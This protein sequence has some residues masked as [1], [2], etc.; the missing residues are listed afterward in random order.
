MM[1]LAETHWSGVVEMKDCLAQAELENAFEN[2]CRELIDL[3]FSD[4]SA[5]GGQAVQAIHD[6]TQWV[7]PPGEPLTFADVDRFLWNDHPRTASSHRG[8]FYVTPK[9]DSRRGGSWTRTLVSADHEGFVQYIT[10]FMT[11]TDPD[12]FAV[13]D[14]DQRGYGYNYLEQEALDNDIPD[15]PSLTYVGAF[16]HPVDGLRFE[17]TAFSDPQGNGTFGAL[18]WRIAEVRNPATAGYR[19]GERWRYE[20]D[21]TWESGEITSEDYAVQVPPVDLVAGRTYRVR[22]RHK[23]STERWSHWSATMPTGPTAKRFY[24]VRRVR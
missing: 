13:G 2:R 12:G 17:S 19:A 18:E 8:Q 11:D 20:I 23:D 9:N 3:M 4:A 1:F 14:G 10:D 5:T 7:N 21:A 24:R 16:R 22:V 15:T 6:L